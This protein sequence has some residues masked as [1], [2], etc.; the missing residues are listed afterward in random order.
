MRG[1]RFRLRLTASLTDTLGR[2]LARGETYAF[3]VPVAVAGQAQPGV[4]LA[5]RPALLYDS[6]DAASSTLAGTFLGGQPLLFHGLWHDPVTGFAYA[7]ARWYDARNAS[8]LS[9]DPAQ[10]I[11][12]PNLYAYV[13]WQPQ[14]ATDPMGLCLGLDD[15]PCSDYATEFGRQFSSPG[16]LWASAGRSGRFG[17]SELKGAALAI[18]RA[19]KGIY[20]VASHPILTATG[21]YELGKSV[22]TDFSGSVQRVGNA[23]VNADPDRTG[24]FVGETLFF[25]G[26]GAA[27]KTA[28]GAAAL[29]QVGQAV[30][31]SRAQFGRFMSESRMVRGR[32]LEDV[33]KAQKVREGASIFKTQAGLNGIDLGTV[34]EASTWLNEVKFYKGRVSAGEITSFG[35]K[36][37][38]YGYGQQVL[39][40]NLGRAL[41]GAEEAGLDPAISALRSPGGYGVR[42]V[43]GPRTVFDAAEITSRLAARGITNVTFQRI[44]C[45]EI[46]RFILR[47]GR[48]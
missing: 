22:V 21:A 46:A 3:D 28:E 16:E 45:R 29:Q 44:T 43:G 18:P 26:L 39:A 9:E 35:L 36:Y 19:A 7:R 34:E 40:R 38:E 24:E 4:A 14:M 20:Q 33:F 30:S 27:A 12:S 8:W 10:D 48:P 25:A 5:Q 2:A 41:R 23:L 13:A 37:P 47:G 31:A 11:D 42:L 1:T 32:F 15:V 17:L 6:R